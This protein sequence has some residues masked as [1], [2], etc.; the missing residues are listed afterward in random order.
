M[1]IH[2]SQEFISL[3]GRI[4][5]Q[6][7]LHPQATHGI[8]HWGRVLENGLLLARETG[9]DPL[10]VTLFAVFHDACRQNEGSDHGH[11]TRGAALA[12]ALLAGGGMLNSQQ[13]ERLQ[14]A[15]ALHTDG[16]IEGEVTLQACWDADRLDLA[17]VG[18]VPDPHRLCSEHARNRA[19]IRWASDRARRRVQPEFVASSWQPLFNPG[20]QGAG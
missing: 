4:A 9:A 16:L 12:G 1:S 10:V 18:T 11:G 17:R 2:Q 13:L 7:R 14:Q 15:C 20:L 19:T 5:A 3:L 8:G 6:Y